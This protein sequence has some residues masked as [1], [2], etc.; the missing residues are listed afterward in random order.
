MMDPAKAPRIYVVDRSGYGFNLLVEGP[1]PDPDGTPVF[2][3]IPG[4]GAIRPT[5]NAAEVEK[6]LAQW[7][8]RGVFDVR[9]HTDFDGGLPAGVPGRVV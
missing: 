6:H 3:C 5:L 1:M 2:I 9:T 4:R 7:L 8:S